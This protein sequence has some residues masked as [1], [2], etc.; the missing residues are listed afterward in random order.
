[1]AGD[2]L[3]SRLDSSLGHAAELQKTLDGAVSERA[4]V[5]AQ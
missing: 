2:D 1:V 4:S 3:R 5:R